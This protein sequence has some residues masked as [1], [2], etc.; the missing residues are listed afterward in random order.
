MKLNRKSL[1]CVS[2]CLF[3]LHF[4]M[5]IIINTKFNSFFCEVFLLNGIFLTVT[6]IWSHLS[7]TYP[8]IPY[9]TKTLTLFWLHFFF[10]KL[11]YFK[12]QQFGDLMS[13][14][15]FPFHNALF[16]TLIRF[17]SLSLWTTK[18]SGEIFLAGCYNIMNQFIYSKNHD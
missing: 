4:L 1:V 2:F 13:I 6:A 17:F 5:T 18:I 10:L 9:L 8:M 11:F 16:F 7:L 3:K 14:S 12:V 15:L